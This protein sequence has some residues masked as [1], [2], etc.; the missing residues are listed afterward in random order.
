MFKEFSDFNKDLEE[1]ARKIVVI[2]KFTDH[3][4]ADKYTNEEIELIDRE[5]ERRREEWFARLRLARCRKTDAWGHTTGEDV[6]EY[7]TEE[8]Y[9]YYLKEALA[10]SPEQRYQDRKEMIMFHTSHKYM[11]GINADGGF[12]CG[13][14][15]NYHGKCIP[16]CRYY[17]ETG[18]IEDSEIIESF[19]KHEKPKIISYHVDNEGRIIYH[20]PTNEQQE[21]KGVI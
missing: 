20:F 14:H 17:P 5:T 12:G 4:P 2:D 16:E 8:E 15:P 21:E 1:L 11:R 18:R 3:T 7:T 13:S 19:E 10:V 9:N 6:Y